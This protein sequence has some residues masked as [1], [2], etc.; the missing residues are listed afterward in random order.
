MDADKHDIERIKLTQ[1]SAQFAL[2]ATPLLNLAALLQ[3]ALRINQQLSNSVTELI[4][5]KYER[6]DSGQNG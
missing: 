2:K 6:K 1:Q 4:Q 3:E 5:E